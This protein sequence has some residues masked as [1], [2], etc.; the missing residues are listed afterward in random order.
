MRTFGFGLVLVTSLACAAPCSAV[1][2]QA[3][4]FDLGVL[5]PANSF[6]TNPALVQVGLRV[7]TVRPETVGVDFAL[8]TLPVAATYGVLLLGADL[9]ASWTVALSEGVRLMPRVGASSAFGVALGED[10]G[11]GGALGYNVGIGLLQRTSPTTAVRLDYTY[12][13]FGIDRESL[14]LSSLTIGFVWMH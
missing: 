4:S 1:A 3:M 9:D 5:G 12:R 11:A 2:Q 8:A 14:A 7:A 10:G 6:Q 13:R